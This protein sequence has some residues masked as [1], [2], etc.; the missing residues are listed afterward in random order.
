M[1]RPADAQCLR[2]NIRRTAAC[3]ARAAV[4]GPEVDQRAW[5]CCWNGRH[6]AERGH[7]GDDQKRERALRTRLGGGIGEERHARPGRGLLVWA[8]RGGWRR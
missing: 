5:R 6:V 7:G 4:V 8:R 1:Y 2:S 3:L